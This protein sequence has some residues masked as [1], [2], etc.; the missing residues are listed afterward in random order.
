[1]LPGLRH[2]AESVSIEL[3]PYEVNPGESTFGSF[4]GSNMLIEDTMSCEVNLLDM[5]FF[6]S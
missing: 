6:K 5:L 4:L 3:S 1:M 2:S